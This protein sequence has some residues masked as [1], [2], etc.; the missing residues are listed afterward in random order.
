MHKNKQL[1]QSIVKQVF[2]FI[3]HLSEMFCSYFT[4]INQNV[5]FILLWWFVRW[6]AGG[7]TGAVLQGLAS[8]IC[9]KQHVA[10]LCIFHVAFFCV[11]SV[12]MWCIHFVTA[13][14]W[15]KSS[16]ILLESSNFHMITNLSI[17]VHA[18]TRHLLTSLSVYKILF[19]V[20]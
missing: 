20:S 7:R 14:A 10:I 9:S 3:A 11:S 16:F 6:E 15:K 2:I 18:F 4:S 8:R 1:K 13:T 12:S 19:C 17:A 5:L